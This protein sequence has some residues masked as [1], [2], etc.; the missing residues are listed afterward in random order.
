M[1]PTVS[2]RLLAAGETQAIATRP[3]KGMRPIPGLPARGAKGLVIVPTDQA[4][5]L[6]LK[7]ALGRHLRHATVLA[8]KADGTDLHRLP[9]WAGKVDIPVTEPL[10]ILVIP[11][12]DGSRWVRAGPRTHMPA[13]PLS[14]LEH[15][16]A[17][18]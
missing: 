18:V 11:R 2:G 3:I 5:T 15:A 10:A 1:T 9:V 17:Y 4:A 7:F 14:K 8:A 6:S 16:L 12:S 13:S